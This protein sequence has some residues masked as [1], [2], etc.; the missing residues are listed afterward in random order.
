[1]IAILRLCAVLCLL[2]AFEARSQSVVFINPGK[3]DEAYW[4]TAASAMQ[5]AANGLGM[6][7]EVKFA[8]RD[9]VRAVEIARE[10]AAL[11]KASRPEYAIITNDYAT[12]PEILRLL[13]GAGIKTFF[14]FSSIPTADRAAL[15][16][17]REKYKGWLGSLEPHAEDAGYMTAKALLQE[18]RK[19][20]VRGPDGKVHVIAIAGDRTTTS[21]IRRND[22]MLKAMSEAPDVH[23]VQ[24]VYAAWNREKAAEQAE[25]LFERYPH[26]RAVWAGNDLMAFGAMQAWEKRGGTVGKDA[27]FSGVNTSKEAMDA[28]RS[29]RLILSGGHFICGA[30]AM[31]MIHDYA[32]G[33]DFADEGLELDRTMFTLFDAASAQ[34]YM[35]LYGENFQRIDFRRHS[36]VLNPSLKRY[37]FDFGQLLR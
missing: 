3:T 6:K 28:V 4:A 17:P 1:M 37:D 36:K 27:W 9:H 32:R 7:L 23:L 24:T 26:A 12:G 18:A 20:K 11:P 10:I 34:R 21:S 31:V 8:Q 5:A 2:L 13:D 19:G 33:R 14:A 35:A 29:G 16:D 25:V 30:W 22:G 15:G